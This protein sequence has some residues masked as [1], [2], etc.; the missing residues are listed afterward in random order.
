MRTESK[1]IGDT[2]RGRRELLNL[3]QT[4]LAAIAG[5][6]LRTLQELETGKSNPSLDTLIK[7]ITPLGLTLKLTL[8]ETGG[9]DDQI[10]K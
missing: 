1:I 6:G 8:K 9:H 4:E 7:I 5:V 3:L 2:I 10:L